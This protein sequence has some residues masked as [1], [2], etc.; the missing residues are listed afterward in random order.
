[1]ADDKITF[2]VLAANELIQVDMKP[3]LSLNAVLLLIQHNDRKPSAKLKRMKKAL[4][5]F[6][7]LIEPVYAEDNSLNI[8]EIMASLQDTTKYKKVARTRTLKNIGKN[9]DGDFLCLIIEDTSDY[10]GT[11][12]RLKEGHPGLYRCLEITVQV[13]R[14]WTEE[15]IR[16]NG[17]IFVVDGHTSEPDKMKQLEERLRAKR[18]FRN[19]DD[20]P[21]LSNARRYPIHFAASYVQN[22]AEESPV[23]VTNTKEFVAFYALLRCYHP[24][25]GRYM[26]ATSSS[27]KAHA[28]KANFILPPFFS[29]RASDDKLMYQEDMPLNFPLFISCS[30]YSDLPRKYTPSSDF[31]VWLRQLNL[32]LIIAEVVPMKN[33]Q[34]CNRMLLQA[35]CL[36]R[37]AFYL[38]RPGSRAH[39]FII[40]IYLT[41]DMIVERYIVMRS[42]TTN[43]VCIQKRKFDIT[44][45]GEAAAFQREM[46]NLVSEIESI[47]KEL[48]VTKCIELE[49]MKNAALGM[50]SLHS[51]GAWTA[52]ERTRVTEM[53]VI[54]EAMGEA[55]DEDDLG[56]FGD[57]KIL[58]NLA[59]LNYQVAY[60]TFGHPNIAPIQSLTGGPLVGCLKHVRNGGN[61]IE[62]LQYLAGL[63]FESNHTVRPIRT[64]PIAG[65]SIIV[66]P[67]AGNRLTKL[68]DKDTYLWPV[69]KQLFEAVKFMHDNCVAHMDLKPSNLLIPSEYGTLTVIDFGVSVRVKRPEKLFQSKG[70]V[71]TEGYIA[72][73]VGRTKFNPIRADLWSVGKVVEEFCVL[74][75][76]S[77]L[78]DWLLALSKRLLDDDP[79]KRPMMSE[80]LQEILNYGVVETSVGDDH[81]R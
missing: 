44:K 64:W 28:L 6:Y 53:D 45:D 11:V 42:E 66:M 65:G 62:I 73:E 60:V 1:M 32:P 61:E 79:N 41:A 30:G 70:R 72:P 2:F 37:L 67:L 14:Q 68:D 10:E 8:P 15:D 35:I 29:G 25:A 34:D 38:L 49:A 16:L 56:V 74:C 5:N 78:R 7:T 47:V 27:L 36:A 57:E 40:A 77:P 75:Q 21:D 9:F 12:K 24:D 59:E 39:P 19:N 50:M 22:S 54:D 18:S 26:A 69:M 20:D 52:N 4:C 71:G 76:P 31:S 43:E 63:D 58:A 46:Y 33:E 48:D 3:S 23:A 55:Q 81:V 80:V 17:G 13:P 51:S